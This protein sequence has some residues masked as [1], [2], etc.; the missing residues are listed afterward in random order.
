MINQIGLMT[1][2]FLIGSEPGQARDVLDPHTAT[3][4]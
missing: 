4:N 3:G 1:T 2:T